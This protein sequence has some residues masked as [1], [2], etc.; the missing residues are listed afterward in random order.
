MTKDST[1]AEINALYISR[2]REILARGE[3][4]TVPLATSD[5]LP[6]VKP[7]D[8]VEFKEA[9]LLDLQKG[10]FVMLYHNGSVLL[11]RV[12]RRVTEHSGDVFI[13]SSNKEGSEGRYEFTGI[14]GKVVSLYR[15]GEK[16]RPKG[17]SVWKARMRRKLKSFLHLS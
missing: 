5:M 6:H 16:L 13:L 12:V 9:S 4:V 10:D 2:W 3:T 7:G 14:L 15:D 8:I 11:R 1:R 17:D